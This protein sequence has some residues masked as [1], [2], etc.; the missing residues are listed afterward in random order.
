MNGRRFR[1]G[2]KLFGSGLSCALALAVL[3]QHARADDAAPGLAH[4]GAADMSDERARAH[5]KAGTSLY[6]SGR[7]PEAAEEWEQA[8]ALSKRDALLYNIYV[9]HRDASNL[10][11]A[12]DALTRY[13]ATNDADAT[14][15][16]NLEARLHSMQ[17]AQA[18]ADEQKRVADANAAQ[19]AP[20]QEAPAPAAAPPPP[21][22]APT[23]RSTVLPLTLVITGGALLTGSL[24]TGLMTQSKVT[25]IENSCPKNTCPTS[26]DLESHRSSARTLATVTDVLLAGGVVVAGVGVVLFFTGGN[27][28]SETHAARDHASA[29]LTPSFVCSTTGCAGALHGTF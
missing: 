29:S 13:L 21:A 4:M 6:Q 8:Y 26:Y 19:A 28:S 5:F 12:I 14:E 9:A 23:H 18:A 1:F 27:S 24:V 10:P 15:R 20:A 22:P 7:F 17:A 16:L 2:S 11:K 25:E 3:V